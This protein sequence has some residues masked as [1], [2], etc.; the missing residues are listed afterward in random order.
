MTALLPELPDVVERPGVA[1]KGELIAMLREFSASK[2]RSQQQALGPSEIGHPCDRRLALGLVREERCN[3][4]A[5]DPLPSIVGTGAHAQMEDMLRWYN[6][7]HGARFLIEQRVYPAPGFG[8][9]MDAYDMH[10]AAVVDWKFPGAT[11]MTNVR[12]DDDPGVVYAT[13]AHLYGLGAE[14]M[15]LPVR[16]V[17]I[18]ALPRGGFS[19]GAHV[20]ERPYDRAL[21]QAALD[22]MWSTMVMAHD[23][24]VG[25]HPERYDLFPTTPHMCEYCPF[26]AAKPRGPYQCGGVS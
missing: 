8:G 18:V 26:F 19:T 12:K 6:A 10:E 13:Q 16:T 15:G 2:P 22:R 5:G 21:A 17:R 20:W 25:E 11:K 23:L 3:D 4:S 14:N 7:T 9:T 1:F 24:D